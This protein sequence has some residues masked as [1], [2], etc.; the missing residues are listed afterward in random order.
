MSL[1]KHLTQLPCNLTVATSGLWGLKFLI[2][3]T[4]LRVGCSHVPGL[5]VHELM[6]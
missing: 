2:V 3:L 6:A 1:L 5:L 4:P